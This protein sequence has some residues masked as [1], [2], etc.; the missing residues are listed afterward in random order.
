MKKLKS[1]PF[2]KECKEKLPRPTGK[3]PR[4]GIKKPFTAVNGLMYN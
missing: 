4:D 1:I 2:T 3:P